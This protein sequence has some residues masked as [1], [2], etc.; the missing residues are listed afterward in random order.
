LETQSDGY[1]GVS[2][3][4]LRK[5]AIEVT[6]SNGNGTAFLLASS[7]IGKENPLAQKILLALGVASIGYGACRAL[8]FLFSVLYR[9]GQLAACAVSRA[10]FRISLHRAAPAA[11]AADVTVAA[12]VE[13]SNGTKLAERIAR[14]TVDLA[15]LFPRAHRDGWVMDTARDSVSENGRL[16]VARLLMHVVKFPVLVMASWLEAMTSTTFTTAGISVD[17]RQMLQDTGDL[18]VSRLVSA[19]TLVARLWREWWVALLLAII[20]AF[21][22][23]VVVH[24]STYYLHKNGLEWPSEYFFPLH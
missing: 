20:A 21:A 7:S 10:F 23:E 2:P 19:K 4:I 24:I 18:V 9:M 12:E 16:K 8:W 22:A 3:S 13:P 1:I 11:Y 14:V 17:A 15:Q 5:V 6:A